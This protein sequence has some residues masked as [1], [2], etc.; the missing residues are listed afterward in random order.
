MPSGSS[1]LNFAVVNR[2]AGLSQPTTWETTPN[3]NMGTHNR[4]RM[5]TA[6]PLPSRQIE[7]QASIDLYNYQAMA[8]QYLRDCC[9]C[10]F[11][12]CFFCFLLL[13]SFATY[14]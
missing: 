9:C 1:L 12:F 4:H 5:P 13:F 6:L 11:C 14:F 7:M 10:C 3:D 2:T 8:M